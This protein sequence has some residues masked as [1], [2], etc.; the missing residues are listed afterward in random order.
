VGVFGAQTVQRK[1]DQ[2]SGRERETVSEQNR[3][4][5]QVRGFI[6]E[7]WIA[8]AAAAVVSQRAVQDFLSERSLEFRR[9][10]FI[11]EGGV[12][13]DPGGVGSL[14]GS[15]PSARFNLKHRVPK[16]G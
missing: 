16:N 2:R 8:F 7:F 11:H 3:V 6:P 13:D 14:V 10:E 4:D 9:I 5:G 15:E 12:I 1:I